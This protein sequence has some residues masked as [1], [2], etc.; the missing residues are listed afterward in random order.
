MP[1]A[2][3]DLASV[4]VSAAHGGCGQVHA[5]PAP[6]GKPVD[7]WE[8]TCEPCS[9]YLRTDPLWAATLSEVGET[10]D[11]KLT[12]E[13]FEKRGTYDRDAVMAMAMAK[14]AGVELPETLRR[15]LTGLKP[16]IA[17][18]S[19]KVVCEAGHDNEPGSKFCGE[20]G[21]TLR[22]PSKRTCPDGHEVAAKM[23]FCGECGKPVEAPARAL[24]PAPE[25]PAAVPD[26]KVRLKDR[27]AE[28]LRQIAR[29]KGLDDS[30]TRA[31]LLA[32]LQAA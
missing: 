26:R 24:E 13:D 30:G 4:T 27:R 32:R 3:S 9:A 14:L 11:E 18:T 16:H 25:P 28:E 15:P 21:V 17:V 7:V 29:N 5:R 22:A 19:G 8:L 10:P 23:R 20:C 2:R 12:R 6:G 1:F 31:D